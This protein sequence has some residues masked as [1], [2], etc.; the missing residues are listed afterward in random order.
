MTTTTAPRPLVRNRDQLE[1]RWFY[2][3]G[4]QLMHALAADTGGAFIL[5]ETAMVQDKLTPLH[6]H[7]ADESLYVLDG[8]LLIHIDGEE[9]TLTT[10]GFTL[11]PAGVPHAFKVLSPTATVLDFQTPG[12]CE[13]F[14]LGASEPLA[15]GATTCVV[16]FDRIKESGRVNGGFELVGPPPF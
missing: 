12:T 13:A 6:T 14:Y 1:R 11:A 16:D 2:G 4:I 9:F 15:P 8:E 3:G 7:P 5:S 10:G